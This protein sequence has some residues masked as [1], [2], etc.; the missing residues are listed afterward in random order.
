[1]SNTPP[2]LNFRHVVLPWAQPDL[3]LA[4]PADLAHAPLRDEAATMKV[5][6][7]R[8]STQKR[9]E[10]GHPE[11]SRAKAA[12]SGLPMLTPS[13][14]PFKPAP[15]IPDADRPPFEA[16]ALTSVAVALDVLSTLTRKIPEGST[17]LADLTAALLEVGTLGG[18]DDL[19]EERLL[20][21]AG[22][23]AGQAR[24]ALGRQV[25]SRMQAL[26]LPV[27]E[28]TA[29]AITLTVSST[30]RAVTK[31][32]RRIESAAA[33]VVREARLRL[34]AQEKGTEYRQA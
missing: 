26:P 12:P 19:A 5:S 10:N 27:T 29:T 9:A 32:V 31:A 20:A 30:P 22:S 34:E 28:H 4:T 11:R 14:L 23:R 13:T 21:H 17:I 33:V 6:P 7:D 8:L 18:I 1:M 2:T 15:S 3:K 16:R 24:A 25:V